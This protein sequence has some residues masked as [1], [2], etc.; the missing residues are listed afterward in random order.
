MMNKNVYVVVSNLSN[1]FK[2]EGVF[3]C[4]SYAEKFCD[5]ENSK[6]EDFRKPDEG[7]EYKVYRTDQR[8]VPDNQTYKKYWDYCININKDVQGYGK[9]SYAGDNKEMVHIN[10]LQNVEIYEGDYIYCRSYVSKTEAE[11]LAKEQWQVYEQ[12]SILKGDK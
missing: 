10:K 8:C 1:E 4:C 7:F 5:V 12:R 2:V 6:I 9:I 11:N 3:S